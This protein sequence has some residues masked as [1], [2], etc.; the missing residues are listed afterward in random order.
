MSKNNWVL[1]RGLTRGNAHWGYFP[2]VFQKDHPDI[3]IELLE[4]PGNGTFNDIDTPLDPIEAVNLIRNRCQFAKNNMKFHLCGLSLGGM[5]ALKWAELY[6]DEIL[7]VS[8][9]NT[10]LRQYSHFFQRLNPRSYLSILKAICAKNIFQQEKLI[11]KITSNNFPS[12]Q[13]KLPDFVEF[14]KNHPVSAKNFFRQLILASKIKIQRC[15]LIPLKVI[16]SQ[17][18]RLVSCVCSQK[19]AAEFGGTHYVNPT[20]GHDIPL[21][22]PQWL[23]QVLTDHLQ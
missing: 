14:F 10:S 20:A 3:A 8:V 2:E 6:P 16:W 7:S 18:D 4:I 9:V 1:L 13:V 15:P 5:I 12:T 23:S 21:D 11:L 19:I 22:D 17:N